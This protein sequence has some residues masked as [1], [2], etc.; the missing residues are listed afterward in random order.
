MSMFD[1]S[2]SEE[3]KASLELAEQ[4]R[5]TEWHHPSFALQ[6]FDGFPDRALI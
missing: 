3:E 2:I 1:K 5:E 6:L 4:S